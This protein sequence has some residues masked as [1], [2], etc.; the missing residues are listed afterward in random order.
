MNSLPQADQI[1]LLHDTLDPGPHDAKTF[2]KLET[3]WLAGDL[4]KLAHAVDG[5]GAVQDILVAR[6]NALWAEQLDHIL[7]EPDPV[8]VTVGALHLAGPGNL[9]DLLTR[10][11]YTVERLQ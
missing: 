6:R 4:D 7:H 5:G 9:R 1:G 8:L 3:T 2:R 11:G 10:R